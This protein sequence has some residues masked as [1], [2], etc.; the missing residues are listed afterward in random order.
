MSG[1]KTSDQHPPISARSPEGERRGREQAHARGA[2]SAPKAPRAPGLRDRLREVLERDRALSDANRALANGFTDEESGT[3]MRLPQAPKP[4]ALE[5]DEIASIDALLN[6]DFSPGL[7]ASAPNESAST[8]SADGAQPVVPQAAPPVAAERSLP[9]A[10]WQ[11]ARAWR[12]A[13]TPSS[14]SP[15]AK[16]PSSASPGTSEPVR[17][18]SPAGG[19]ERDLSPSFSRSPAREVVS[20]EPE[21]EGRITLPGPDPWDS[22][23]A[24]GGEPAASPGPS[25]AVLSVFADWIAE[26]VGGLDDPGPAPVVL[27]PEL[28]PTLHTTTLSAG[29]REEA[30]EPRSG[31]EPIRTRT[32]ARLLAGHGY[33]AR[34][35]SIYDELLAWRPDDA[36]LRAEAD[37]LRRTR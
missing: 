1:R 33:K 22:A 23:P 29:P 5:P 4:R 9:S 24:V 36:E 37:A 3:R 19:L 30:E 31:S 15:A 6:G 8:L 27:T 17:S 25:E 35:L 26:E 32:M 20:P 13:K 34:A 12:G 18:E 21:S 16:T 28:S 10:A 7:P 14:A 11:A 2:L